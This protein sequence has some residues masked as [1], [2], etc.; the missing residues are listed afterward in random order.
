V[1]SYVAFLRG[2][3]V[4]GNKPIKMDALKKAFVA[5]GFR[6]VKTVLVSGNAVFE[7]AKANPQKIAAEIEAKIEKAFGLE[8][9][10]VVRTLQQLQK[11]KKADPFKGI[12][13]TPETRLYVTFLAHKPTGKPKIEH[14]AIVRITPTE[15]CTAISLSPGLGTTELMKA[16]DKEFGRSVTTRNWNTIEKILNTATSSKGS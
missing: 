16:L 12:R 8:V 6:N 4:G 5:L 13:V 2:I 14:G 3:N 7:T 15:V 11:L 9:G 10:V 1:P